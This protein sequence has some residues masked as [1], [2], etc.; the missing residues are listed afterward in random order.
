[1]KTTD[2]KFNSHHRAQ[3]RAVYADSNAKHAITYRMRPNKS[4]VARRR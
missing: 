2:P 4:E 3:I 1:M